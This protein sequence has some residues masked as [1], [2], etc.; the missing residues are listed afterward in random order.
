MFSFVTIIADNEP[1]KGERIN[2]FCRRDLWIGSQGTS[3]CHLQVCSC[4]FLQGASEGLCQHLC[5]KAQFLQDSSKAHWF[6]FECLTAECMRSNNY[7]KGFWGG[8]SSKWRWSSIQC[9]LCRQ[10]CWNTWGSMFC[11]EAGCS[12]S[13]WAGA[14]RWVRWWM[15]GTI[16]SSTFISYYQ[17]NIS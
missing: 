10:E 6:W 14:G 11:L 15:R 12:A 17:P 3:R 1:I 2:D 8:S 13:V 5:C 4:S 16:V 7:C 9:W